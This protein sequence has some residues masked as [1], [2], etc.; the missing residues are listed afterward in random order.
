M[1]SNLQHSA[2]GD[3][4]LCVPSPLICLFARRR[5]PPP[6]VYSIG[7]RMHVTVVPR[8]FVCRGGLHIRPARSRLAP[9][10]GSWQR[11]CLRGLA[12]ARRSAVGDAVLCVPSPLICLFARRRGPPPGVYSIGARI[13]VTVVPRFFVCRGGLHIRPARSLPAP[14]WGSWQRSCLRGLATARLSRTG[15]RGRRPLRR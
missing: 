8:F 3:A 9:R 15:R 5:G 12:A 7:T 11:S 6:G 13:H 4:V 14:R 2:V 10:W 1:I